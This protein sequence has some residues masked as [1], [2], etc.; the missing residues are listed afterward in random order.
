MTYNNVFQIEI[1]IAP[2]NQLNSLKSIAEPPVNMKVQGG[3][4]NDAYYC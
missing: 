4:P 2:E 3:P 1:M